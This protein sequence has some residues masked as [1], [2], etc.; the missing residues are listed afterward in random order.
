[1]ITK[2][3]DKQKLIA[4]QSYLSGEGF[5]VIAKRL[6]TY[7]HIVKAYLTLTGVR[8]P[9]T[10]VC[11]RCLTHFTDKTGKNRWCPDCKPLNSNYNYQLTKEQEKQARI[12]SNAR[13]IAAIQGVKYEPIKKDNNS[14]IREEESR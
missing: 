5:S 4:K 10:S 3:D 12:E 1:M 14:G 9:Y 8:A 6:N 11:K 7:A 13:K 2:L